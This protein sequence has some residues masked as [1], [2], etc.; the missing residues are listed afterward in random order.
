V[1]LQ[2]VIIRKILLDDLGHWFDENLD[3][4][5]EYDFFL[6]LLYK[7]MV[8]YN[9][10]PLVIYRLHSNMSSVKNFHKSEE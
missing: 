10:G 4:S 6:R 8:G 3:L 2:T 7:T 1:N 5:E 9:K